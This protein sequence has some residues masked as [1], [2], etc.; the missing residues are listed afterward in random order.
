MSR[1]AYR[2]AGLLWLV[3]AASAAALQPGGPP[4]PAEGVRLEQRLAAIVERGP[5]NSDSREAVVLPE[6]EVN[7]YLEFRAQLP[8][9]VTQPRVAFAGGGRI[10]ARAQVDLQAAVE[11]VPGALRRLQGLLPVA[12]TARFD[13]TDGL[14]RVTIE[15]M[16][17]AGI[18]VPGA[19]VGQL[20]DAFATRVPGA[21]WLDFDEPFRLPHRIR[22][23]S[24]DI[25]EMVVVQ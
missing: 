14:G 3:M 23:I 12:I 22:H 7:A 11:S 21:A 10:V 9:G 4:T 19:V 20:L 1:T 17:V 18:S 5:R 25:G 16:T 8:R 13:A 2:P 24:V 15:S 6:R